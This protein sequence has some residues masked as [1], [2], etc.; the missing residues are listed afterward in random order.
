MEKSWVNI[1]MYE[2]VAS[3]MKDSVLMKTQYYQIKINK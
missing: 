1:K 3:S 2:R